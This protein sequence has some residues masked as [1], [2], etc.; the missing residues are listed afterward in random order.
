MDSK[1]SKIRLLLFLAYDHPSIYVSVFF[2]E[3]DVQAF[4]LSYSLE[5]GWMDLLFLLMWFAF[6][7][8]IFIA[9]GAWVPYH[10]QC[11][12]LFFSPCFY[13]FIFPNFFCTYFYIFFIYHAWISYSGLSKEKKYLPVATRRIFY[14]NNYKILGIFLR[15]FLIEKHAYYVFI[16]H[17]YF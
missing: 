12:H 9:F 17:I 4:L 16:L 15:I 11:L 3:F 2:G 6:A 5:I 8:M 7:S 14:V 10:L 13:D 1:I